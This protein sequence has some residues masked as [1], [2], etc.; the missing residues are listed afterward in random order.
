VPPLVPRATCR[1]SRNMC[2][3]W[4]PAAPSQP[5]RA[6]V[7]ADRLAR[8]VRSRRAMQATS[9]FLI[10]CAGLAA[11]GGTVGETAA[12][13]GAA[14][15]PDGVGT[16]LGGCPAA[17]PTAGSPCTVAGRLCTWTQSCGAG[18]VGWCTANKQW[19]VSVGICQPGCPAERP[20]P[21]LGSQEG[22]PP[23]AK[24][25]A[26]LECS[27]RSTPL[28]SAAKC[29]CSAAQDGRTVWG[30]C[31]SWDDGWKPAPGTSGG[32]CGDLAT[33]GGRSGCGSTCPN[34]EPRQ[35]GC[36]QDGVLYCAVKNKC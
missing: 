27:Y 29:R 3:R 16:T 28:D 25:T 30:L 2:R 35:C 10:F 9:A 7:P 13:A 23:D 17:E 34:A 22:P 1:S 11:C 32:A 15:P 6:F 21:S 19:Q 24:C 14:P 8:V 36:G 31:D 20:G 26:G 12:S 18:D 4:P 33:C 5:G